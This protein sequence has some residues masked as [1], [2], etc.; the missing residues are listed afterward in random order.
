MIPYG[1]QNIDDE[2]I[3]AVV[4]VLKSDWLTTGP[5]IGEF[6]TAVADY[7]GTS[8]AV[9][10]NSGTAALHAMMAALQ[11]G[12]NDEVIVPAM[13]FAATA[14]CVVFQGAT[15]IFAD[16]DPAT[17]LICPESVAS[18]VTAKT[19]AI[20]AVDYAGQPC[21]Y[22]RLRQIADLHNVPL[23][24]DGC[25]SLGARYKH[26]S[27]GNLAAMTA[28]S[29]HPV[30]PI[31]TGEGGMIT[32]NDVAL[33]SEMRRFRNHG[34]VTD[35]R[36]R[37]ETGTWFY[38]M[39]S[40]GFNYRISDIQ[41]ALGIQQLKKLDTWIERRHQIAVQYDEA[42]GDDDG[43]EPLARLAESRHAWHLYVVRLKHQSR[44]SVFRRLRTA[45]IG[46]NVHYIP[47]H[48]HPFYRQHFQTGPGLCPNAESAYEQILSLPVYPGMT[49][50]QVN[51]VT[52]QL[53]QS[54]ISSGRAA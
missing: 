33:A 16:V 30:K 10:V 3:A 13:T 44:D 39:Q 6:E 34:I 53:K 41:C 45:G 20:I 36:R 11:I 43:I 50:E 14:N 5:K 2:D 8:D 54:A 7:V 9:A 37:Q 28:F 17:L 19:R 48:L 47:V 29:F 51:F 18:L 46:V 42:F 35:A 32:T 52:G 25:H 15:P 49:N 26:Q 1:R 40:L 4:R 21:N 23:L 22:D 27:S 31:T 38:E 12:T 24:T